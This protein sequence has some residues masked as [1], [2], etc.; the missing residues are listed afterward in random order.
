M[1]A[2]LLFAR[3]AIVMPNYGFLRTS[4][5]VREC[6]IL[7]I[8]ILQ[9]LVGSSNATISTRKIIAFFTLSP[10]SYILCLSVSQSISLF[11][12]SAY[13]FD[14]RM[15]CVVLNFLVF[16]RVGVICDMYPPHRASFLR[17]IDPMLLDS[18][19]P[20]AFYQCLPSKKQY[21]HVLDLHTKHVRRTFYCRQYGNIG[22]AVSSR[23][24]RC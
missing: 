9:R 5:S 19:L 2:I 22:V 21:I 8:D 15:E 24:G 6:D 4:D 20:F 14:N 11:R 12:Q 16:L 3:C 10:R 13:R 23:T 1:A 18:R 7:I 17:L